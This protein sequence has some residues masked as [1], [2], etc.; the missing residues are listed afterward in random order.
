MAEKAP[1]PMANCPGCR[2]RGWPAPSGPKNCCPCRWL[3]KAR[4]GK[5]PAPRG[6]ALSVC[7]TSGARLGS[8]PSPAS[9]RPSSFLRASA[10]SFSKLRRP[11]GPSPAPSVGS[12]LPLSGLRRS[13]ERSGSVKR[14]GLVSRIGLRPRGAAARSSPGRSGSGSLS[15]AQ[16]FSSATGREGALVTGAQP[17]TDAAPGPGE[18]FRQTSCWEG[19]VGR[20]SRGSCRS[21]RSKTPFLQRKKTNSGEEN[22]ISNHVSHMGSNSKAYQMF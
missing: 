14:A 12:L 20:T 13:R 8:L 9:L 19:Q 10:R 22:L 15:A 1:G 16:G 7:T 5:W 6:D 18:H 11:N 3:E 21:H 17:Q 4:P 2:K